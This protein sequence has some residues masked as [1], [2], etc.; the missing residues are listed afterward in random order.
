MKK[1][2]LN[3]IADSFKTRSFRAGGYSVAAT[4]MV[5]VMVI[6]LNLM[7]GVLPS[8]LTKFDITENQLYSITEQTQAVLHDLQKE[9]T[10]Y[11]ILTEGNE[12]SYLKSL[13]ELVQEQSS[14]I[15]VV[16]RDTNMYPNFASAYTTEQVYPNSLVVECGEKYR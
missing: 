5:L 9:I 3:A 15:K 8:R 10:V 11:W 16:R 1:F 13:L 7:L 12:D 14:H 6:L 4:A 2:S